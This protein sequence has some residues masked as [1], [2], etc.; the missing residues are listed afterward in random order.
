M[1]KPMYERAIE[2]N[3]LSTIIRNEKSTK[4]VKNRIKGK[5]EE[6]KKSSKK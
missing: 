1:F 3:P 4:I 5:Y 6:A 2:K